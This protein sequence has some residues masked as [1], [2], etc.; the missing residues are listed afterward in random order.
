M[1]AALTT[2]VRI[3]SQQSLAFLG[4]PGLPGWVCFA[5]TVRSTPPSQ[6]PHQEGFP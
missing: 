2:K 4:V 5:E 6:S 1:T 3:F